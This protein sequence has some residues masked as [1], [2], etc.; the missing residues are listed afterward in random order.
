MNDCSVESDLV[1]GTI[2]A[3]L[4]NAMSMNNPLPHD[5]T[6]GEEEEEA[7]IELLSLTCRI[8]WETP[9]STYN[10]KLL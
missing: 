3:T 7:Q 9:Y 1:F 2:V 6:G 8:L 10:M 4:L 5:S